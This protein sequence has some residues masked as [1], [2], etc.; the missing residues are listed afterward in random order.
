MA[1]DENIPSRRSDILAA[2]EQVFEAHGYTATTMDAVAH[3]A[4]IAKGS[5]YNY[6]ASKQELFLDVVHRMFAHDDA[7]GEEL[8]HCGLS[9]TEKVCGLFDL[10]FANLSRYRHVGGL[11]LEFYAAAAR[12]HR[13]GESKASLDALC[14]KHRRVVADIVQQGMDTGEFHET[15]V[16]PNAASLILAVLDGLTLRVILDDEFEKAVSEDI[17]ES[18]KDAAITALRSTSKPLGSPT[19][20]ANG[21]QTAQAHE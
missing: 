20:P 15:N 1:N 11:M 9:P 5:I 8:A 16:P 3:Q 12:E 13:G 18:L 2:A 17:L 10:W 14:E 4:H 6:Y 7:A 21:S 19:A